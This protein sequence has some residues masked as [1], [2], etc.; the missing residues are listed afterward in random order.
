[1]AVTT[2]TVREFA[3][4]L[5]DMALSNRDNLLCISGFTGE[6][7]SCFAYQL[8]KE[9]G[10]ISG[11]GWDINNIT[12]GRKE[13]M[14]W[15]D[16][17]DPAKKNFKGRK[18]MYSAIL[19]DE[20]ISAFNSK[21]WFVEEQKRAVSML[22]TCRDRRLLIAGNV[23]RMWDLENGFTSRVRYMVYIPIRATAWVFQQENNPFNKD[24]WNQSYNT[25]KFRH[26]KMT[27]FKLP[28]FLFEIKYPDWDKEEEDA[29][30]IIR[31]DKR[32]MAQQDIKKDAP[33]RYTKIKKQRDNTIKAMHLV[34][35]I[36]QKEITKHTGI[37]KSQVNRICLGIQ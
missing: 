32:I 18:K 35:N 31:N 26:G 5:Y 10:K 7:K 36:P 33:E 27:P 4:L 28:N 25:K 11:L 24:P 34:Y 1:M 17:E 21:T 37:K 16:G 20:L 2:A 19:F 9:Y 8:C 15:V 29:Y 30:T 6:G 22:N 14:S 3:K 13:F 23:P 12:W